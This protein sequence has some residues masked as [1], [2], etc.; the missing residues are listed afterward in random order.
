MISIAG[1]EIIEKVAEGTVFRSYKA[2]QTSLDRLV[3]IK[4]FIV[5]GSDDQA[6]FEA[7]VKEAK[8]AARLKHLGILQL[9]DVVD[10]GG[11]RFLVMEHPVGTT[12][13]QLISSISNVP[14]KRA[15]QI[16]QEVAHALEYSWIRSSLV[17]GAL[18]PDMITLEDGKVKVIGIGLGGVDPEGHG[19]AAP[20]VNDP[21]RRNPYLAPE[22][23]TGGKPS[24][25]TDIYAAGVILG[26][27][28]NGSVPEFAR[29]APG[30]APSLRKAAPPPG[31]T[32][33]PWSLVMRMTEPDLAARAE[34]WE[35]VI[36][37]IDKVITEEQAITEKAPSAKAAS[38]VRPAKVIN[39][40]KKAAGVGAGDTLVGQPSLPPPRAK[41]LVLAGTWAIVIMLWAVM[42]CG[43]WR[44]PSVPPLMERKTLP[45]RV[46]QP[47]TAATVPAA[48]TDVPPAVSPGPSAAPAPVPASPPPAP[49]AGKMEAL[50]T[51]TAERL[52]REDFVGAMNAI[53]ALL[54]DERMS[55][56][57]AEARSLREFVKQVAGMDA[58]IAD[59]LRA[60]IGSTIAVP[61]EGQTVT[62]ILK[63]VGLG[64]IAVEQSIDQN[65]QA[66]T[67]N[68]AIDI[69]ALGPVERARWL[70]PAQTPA[71]HAMRFILGCQAHS[72]PA[73]LGVDAASS[74]PMAPVFM[75]ITAR[76]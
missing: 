43:L 36:R 59:N 50:V 71:E 39:I 25:R 7:L 40:P 2:R 67:R 9:F 49:T 48:R 75:K 62:G 13:A 16:V 30:Q 26:H 31:V 53:D 63:G 37:I 8:R 21:L 33:G 27:M 64:K 34:K 66:V 45:P 60:K 42:A 72:S 15:L 18:T 20:W 41:P 58:R 54:A 65:T 4:E 23:Q 32:P 44:M 57:Q 10:E 24:L 46:T 47:D 17:H 55:P 28:L 70:G 73:Q 68:H 35:E 29:V 14:Q 22:L 38:P 6:R 52:L 5:A 61:I 3:M 74:G 56:L 51:N 12:V 19:M 76:Q 69:V 11:T 1:F